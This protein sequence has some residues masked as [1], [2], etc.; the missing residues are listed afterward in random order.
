MAASLEQVTNDKKETEKRLIQ[1]AEGLAIRNVELERFN[2]LAVGR[3]LE[4]IQLKRQ[5]NDLVVQMGKPPPYNPR[6]EP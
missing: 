1:Q 2:R 6:N 5:I 4:M 3:E